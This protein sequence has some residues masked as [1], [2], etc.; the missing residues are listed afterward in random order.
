MSVHVYIVGRP[1]GGLKDYSEVIGRLGPI[2]DESATP[3]LA[4]GSDAA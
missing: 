2:P 4:Y 1:A 3:R